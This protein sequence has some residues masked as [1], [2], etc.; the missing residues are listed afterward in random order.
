[1]KTTLQNKFFLS[2]I[3]VFLGISI[4]AQFSCSS[5]VAITNGYTSGWITTPGTGGTQDWVSSASSCAVAASS[6]FTDKDVYMYKY[7]TGNIAGES[8]YI[9]LEQDYVTDGPHSIGVWTSCSTSSLSGCV[10]SA[11]IINKNIIGLCAQNLAANTTYYIGIGKQYWANTYLKFK[12]IEFKVES[13]LTAPNDEC[14]GASPLNVFLPYSGST[15]CNFTASSGSPSSCGTIEND[16]WM[17]FTAGS[18]AITIEY[19][20]YNCSN[21]YGVQLAV[22]RGACGSNTLISGSCINYASNNSSGTWTFS[23]L[24]IGATYYIRADGYAG[25][26]CSYAFTPVSGVLL[27]VELIDFYASSANESSTR[28]HWSTA[29]ETNNAYF[30]VEKSD[31]AVNFHTIGKVRS[32]GNSDRKTDYTLDDLSANHSSTSYYRLK[33]V[34]YDGEFEYSKII[35]VQHHKSNEI[36]VFPNPSSNGIFEI[37]GP[38]LENA[39][40][41]RIYDF[42]GKEVLMLNGEQLKNSTIDL[43]SYQSGIYQLMI[44]NTE[45]VITKKIVVK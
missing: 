4:Q 29:S 5:A 9:T 8:F 30:E 3:F 32:S 34:D 16:S 41:I 18:S 11:Y 7:T 27:P 45:D 25:D 12:I 37:K 6:S 23:G 17:K 39:Q 33:Q 31:D 42:Y 28:L 15:R 14:S 13:S 19:R 35:S 26:L 36:V 1:M 20:V 40:E 38:A 43:S 21:D 24:T 22:F 44:I 2:L 10:T